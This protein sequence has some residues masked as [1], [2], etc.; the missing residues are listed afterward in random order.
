DDNRAQASLGIGASVGVEDGSR[1]GDL[2]RRGG[3]R[4]VDDRHLGGV[5][6]PLAVEA[7]ARR[8]LGIVT[9]G[10]EVTDGQRHAVYAGKA[11]GAGGGDGLGLGVVVVEKLLRAQ[12]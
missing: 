11:G 5:N 4:R 1:A 6:R 9:A 2:L 12:L 7:H 3:E 8:H 10:V